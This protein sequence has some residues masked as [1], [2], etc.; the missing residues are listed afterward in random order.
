MANTTHFQSTSR[1]FG[2]ARVST[3]RQSYDR[4]KAAPEAYNQKAAGEA[5][6]PIFKTY[7]EKT[8]GKAMERAQLRALI[9]DTRPGDT[10]VVSSLDRFGRTTLGILQTM[11]ELAATEVAIKSLKPGE[12]FEGITGK[13][14]LTVMAAI[15]EWERE[16]TNERAADARAARAEK[17]GQ[18]GRSKSALAPGNVEEIVA[19][20]AQGWG[21][22]RSPTGW[23]YLAH[24]CTGRSW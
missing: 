15:A 1:T 20:K 23:G 21:R 16:N 8:S 14:I 7:E 2:Y 19:L 4:Q 13:L 11:E 18:Q 6:E 5:Y 24:R 3:S 22:K 10:I 9:K 12:N 17:E